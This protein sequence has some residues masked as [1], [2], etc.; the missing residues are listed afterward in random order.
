[1]RVT[2]I[3]VLALA[4]LGFS[5][6]AYAA[7]D[8]SAALIPTVEQSQSDYTMLQ[9]YMFL[10]AEAEYDRLK[11]MD[12][13]GREAQASYKMFSA[14]YGESNSREEFRDKAK[15]RLTQE[16]FSMN[17]SEAKAAH[18]RYLTETQLVAWKA[19]VIAQSQAGSVLLQAR[20]ITKEGFPLRVDW[21]PQTGVGEGDLEL[22][23]LGGLING[24]S[25]ITE[26]LVGSRTKSF[27]VVPI[28]DS[29][30]V[31][32]TANI[33]GRSDEF[34]VSLEP[35]G[36]GRGGAARY[37]HSAYVV[38]CSGH[39]CQSDDWG[40]NNTFPTTYGDCTVTKVV[41][42]LDTTRRV[43]FIRVAEVEG[44]KGDP[45]D[46]VITKT[47][48]HPNAY[49][50]SLVRKNLLLCGYVKEN[51]DRRA[52]LKLGITYE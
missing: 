31:V 15:Q 10:N 26:K 7:L 14:E 3:F 6:V 8:C 30:A 43:R 39:A 37:D 17:I 12:K 16:G 32:V 25:Q 23:I 27:I 35:E 40:V 42:D 20:D 38:V 34:T 41:S 48:M 5:T 51:T 24:N 1:M 21:V 50:N 52:I 4:V 33:A 46:F 11:T 2:S 19:C 45:R 47:A 49:D 44:L 18:R 22:N 13:S 9:A 36:T 28:Q 29:K